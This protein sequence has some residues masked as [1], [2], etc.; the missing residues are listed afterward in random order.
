[1][2]EPSGC[3]CW[4]WLLVL[5]FLFW[6]GRRFL[7]WAKKV[8]DAQKGK[9]RKPGS[10]RRGTAPAARIKAVRAKAHSTGDYRGGSYHLAETLRQL[11]QEGR[12]GKALPRGPFLTAR[13]LEA[14]VGPGPLAA[15]FHRL[16]VLRFG[17]DAPTAEAFDAACEEAVDVIQ[18]KGG[19]R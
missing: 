2:L 8:S 16:A 18:K 13:E 14:E 3:S 12:L 10:R 4:W 19:R 17:R 1:M 5:A 9:Q 15:L 11:L 6:L 7:R